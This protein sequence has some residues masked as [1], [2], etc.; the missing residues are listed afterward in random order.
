MATGC[1]RRVHSQ[2]ARMTGQREQAKQLR[3]LEDHDAAF[4]V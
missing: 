1:P 2:K 4:T 3:M